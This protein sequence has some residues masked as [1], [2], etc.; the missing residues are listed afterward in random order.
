MPVISEFY[1][2]V[3]NF[4]LTL[5]TPYHHCCQWQ[6]MLFGSYLDTFPIFAMAGRVYFPVSLML[7][8]AV[9]YG[10]NVSLPKLIL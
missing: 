5:I 3:L 8:L 4:L 7:G 6:I 9:C 2:S 10:L 1:L